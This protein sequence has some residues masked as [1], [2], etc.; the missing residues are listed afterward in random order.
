MNLEQIRSEQLY[1]DIEQGADVITVLKMAYCVGFE[2]GKKDVANKRA[3]IQLSKDGEFIKE[4]SSIADAAKAVC[5]SYQGIST[6]CRGRI[7]SSAGYQWK[8]KN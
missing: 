1:R 3:V 7:K 5:I 4:Y 6:C 8:Y 2:D